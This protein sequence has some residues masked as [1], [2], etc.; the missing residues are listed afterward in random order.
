M[1]NKIIPY[2]PNLKDFVKYL[3]TH[4]TPSEITL[5]NH[6]RKN[7]LGVEF[8]RQVPIL[9]YIVDFYCHELALAIEV[10]GNIHDYNFLEDAQRQEAIEKY[11]V[12]FVRFSNEE[13]NNNL[14]GVIA[15]LEKIISTLRE[16]RIEEDSDNIP[17]APL[18]GEMRRSLYTKSIILNETIK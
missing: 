14:F 15:T 6:I 3:R 13:I 4:S 12:T 16:E 9:Q 11:G 17:P 2:N 18:K 8:H 7:I 5:W 1:P 10:D